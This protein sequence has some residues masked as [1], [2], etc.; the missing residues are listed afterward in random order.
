MSRDFSKL[1]ASRAC[2]KISV[3]RS[4]PAGAVSRGT[5]FWL[6]TLVDNRDQARSGPW[7]CD[8]FFDGSFDGLFG[9]SSV[10]AGLLDANL[11]VKM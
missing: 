11:C 7:A 4:L 9:Y 10:L 1:G 8:S 6:C 3:S 2:R 5:R